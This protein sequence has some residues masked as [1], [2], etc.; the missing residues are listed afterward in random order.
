MQL[1]LL[2]CGGADHPPVFFEPEREAG[3]VQV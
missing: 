2:Q 1:A 3:F